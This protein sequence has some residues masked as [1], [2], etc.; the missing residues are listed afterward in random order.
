MHLKDCRGAQEPC[1][2][3]FELCRIHAKLLDRVERCPGRGD[4]SSKTRPPARVKK[5][6]SWLARQY[7]QGRGLG[8]HQDTVV[9][10]VSLSLSHP[11]L[12]PQC[13][14]GLGEKWLRYKEEVSCMV[15]IALVGK[16]PMKNCSRGGHVFLGQWGDE[17]QS[18]EFRVPSVERTPTRWAVPSTEQRAGLCRLGRQCAPPPHPTEEEPPLEPIARQA[19]GQLPVWKILRLKKKDFK[20]SV[21]CD[22]VNLKCWN[23]GVL[24]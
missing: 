16:L 6:R 20:K 18:L 22:W 2:K 15:Q 23:L 7:V 9:T 3:D 14:C 1:H 5:W 12:S 21:I 17:Q 13:T 19:Q 4:R 11:T 8:R 10:I 24:W